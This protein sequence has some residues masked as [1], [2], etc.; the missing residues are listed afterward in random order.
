MNNKK[1]LSKILQG[2]KNIRFNEM[3][4]LVKAYGF[5]L[6]RVSGSHHIFISRQVKEIVNIQNVGGK[7]K[8]YQVKQFLVLVERYNLKMAEGD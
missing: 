8:P 3:T 6:S 5:C 1:I 7:V 2:N 4:S